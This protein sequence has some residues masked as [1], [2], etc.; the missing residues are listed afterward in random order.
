MLRYNERQW[1]LL[2]QEQE[3]SAHRTRASRLQKWR[4]LSEQARRELELPPEAP[5]TIQFLNDDQQ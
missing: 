3:T 4:E 2:R 5:D 1:A